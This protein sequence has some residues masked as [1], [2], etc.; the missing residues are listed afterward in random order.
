MT[1]QR[2]RRLAACAAITL[3]AASAAG[4]N[5]KTAASVDGAAKQESAAPLGAATLQQTLSS[6]PVTLTSTKVLEDAASP[7]LSVKITATGPFGS[8][9]VEKSDPQRIMV[10]MHNATIGE[11][12]GSIEVNDGTV[13]K[14][15][16]AQL[17]AGKNPAVRITIGLLGKVPFKVVPGESALQLE[18]GKLKGSK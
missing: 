3:L 12:P 18:I 13:G 11:A 1:F 5:E 7:T 14:V 15:D 17:H 10:I 8:N 2:A 6:D 16:I 4:C 9:V